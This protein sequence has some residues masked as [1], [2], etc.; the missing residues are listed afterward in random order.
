MKT[1]YLENKRVKIIAPLKIKTYSPG[2]PSVESNLVDKEGSW[3]QVEFLEGEGAGSRKPT[4]LEL[5]KEK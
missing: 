5:L 1:F 4:T 2:K 3:V